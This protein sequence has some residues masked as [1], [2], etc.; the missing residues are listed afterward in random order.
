MK[1]ADARLA[2]AVAKAKGAGALASPTISLAQGFGKDTGG[3]DEDVLVTQTIEFGDK[4]TQR[5]R[6]ANAEKDAAKSLRRDTLTDLSFT[7]ESAYFDA[8]RSEQDR[9]LASETLASAQRIERTAQTQFQAGDVPRSNV[10]RSGIEIARAEQALAAAQA[11]RDNRYASLR[12]LTGLPPATEIVLTD[13]LNAAQVTYTLP[14]LL[15]RAERQRA[16]IE[17]ARRL[18]DARIAAAKGAKAQNQPD[19]FV[20]GRHS[21]LDPSNGGSS[22]RLGITAPLFDLGRTRSDVRA[23]QAAVQEQDA[24]LSEVLR[25]ARLDV[26][27]SYR[28]LEAARKAVESFTKVRLQRSQELLDMVRIGYERGATSFIEY[29]DAQL[30]YRT[31]QTEHVRALAAYRIAL[32][33]LRR[34]VGGTLP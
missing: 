16:D 18:K 15:T 8:L 6:A 32:A 5:V 12:S 30:V 1:G 13:T 25:T 28:S 19:L 4:R 7:V 9:R 11:D 17:A 29:L 27:T 26:E 31:E 22:I 33:A 21:T 24:V 14:D 2:G 34:S 23:A 10:I 3:L 20:E